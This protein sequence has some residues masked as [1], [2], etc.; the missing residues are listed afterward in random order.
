[1]SGMPRKA[2]PVL[3]AM[4]AAVLAGSMVSGPAG[5]AVPR[6][7]Q[8]A[9]A[10]GPKPPVLG[11]RLPGGPAPGGFASWAQFYAT[12]AR[13]DAAASTIAAADGGGTASIVVNPVHRAL[14][15]YWPGLVPAHVRAL[16]PG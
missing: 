11:G 2:W 5:A 10:A 1:M 4:V 8:G 12:Q 15:V 9:G 13:L 7:L 16:A 6:A 14:T 3:A